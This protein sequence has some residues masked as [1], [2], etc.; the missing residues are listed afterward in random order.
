[1]YWLPVI[2]ALG[3]FVQL[4]CLSFA[5]D[6]LQEIRE[7]KAF[8]LLQFREQIREERDRIVISAICNYI[9]DKHFS[10]EQFEVI[11]NMIQ[12]F[13]SERRLH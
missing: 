12:H 13:M 8:A 5:Y 6:K 9:V 10:E 2:Q 3:L 4:E 1:M 11:S 7:A